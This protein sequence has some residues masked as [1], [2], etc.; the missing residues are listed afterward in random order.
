MRNDVLE[1]PILLDD[2]ELDAV[3]AAGGSLI[4]VETG[5]IQVGV[6]VL[7]NQQQFNDG[8]GKKY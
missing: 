5:N 2:K 8:D 1:T 7:S 4:E 3:A 6:N